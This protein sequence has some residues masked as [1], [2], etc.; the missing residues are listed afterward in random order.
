MTDPRI[1]ATHLDGPKLV[2]WLESEHLVTEEY[3]PGQ[4]SKTQRDTLNRWRRGRPADVGVAD[5]LLIDLGRH[6]EELPDDVFLD[7]RR[8]E[9][10]HETRDR[11]LELHENGSWSRREIGAI[12][13]VSPQTVSRHIRRAA[14]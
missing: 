4:V 13:G 10:D 9:V 1:T 11:I 7:R 12:V 6:I 5:R 3:E 2:E 14:A 8:G